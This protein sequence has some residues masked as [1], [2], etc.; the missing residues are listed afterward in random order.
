[1]TEIKASV[2]M[3]VYNDGKYLTET[4]TSICR[5][6]LKKIE[7][8]C[9]D[10]GSDDDSR[11]IIKAFA[12]KDERVRLLEQDKLSAGAA[13]NKGLAEA[14]GEYV[15]FLDSDDF[16]AEDMLETVCE[17]ADENKADVVVFGFRRYDDKKQKL[18][19]KEELPRKDLLPESEVFSAREIPEAI[20]RFTSPAPW[21]KLFRRSFLK[22]TGLEFQT[23]PNS[24]DFCFI[25]SALS[26][27]ERI[28][29][30]QRALTFYRVNVKSSIQGSKDKNPLCF[31]S[32]V[33]GLYEQL[34]S[35]GSYDFFAES[36][37]TV[38]LS[39]ALYNLRS[40]TSDEARYS[41]L[42]ALG[43]ENCILRKLLGQETELYGDKTTA[44]Y[45]E[46]LLNALSQYSVTKNTKIKSE[47]KQIIPYRG[48][49][50]I[51]VSVVIP[52]YNTGAYVAEAVGSVC[53]QSLK[54]IEIIC[55]NDGSTD[56]SPDVLKKCA[57]LDERISVWTQENAGVSCARNEGIRLAKGRYIYFMDSDDVLAENALTLLTEKADA[58]KLDV[59]YFDADVICDDICMQDEA[60]KFNYR[61][62][63]D[64]SAVYP[65]PVLFQLMSDNGDFIPTPWSQ[66]LRR[67]HIIK[68]GTF[69]HPGVIHED[70]AF[71]FEAVMNA[72]RASHLAQP[73]FFRRI[74]ENS[75]MTSEVSFKNVYGYFVSCLDMLRV[76]NEME[77]SL[78]NSVK[79]AALARISQNLINAQNIYSRIRNEAGRELGLGSDRRCFERLVVRAGNSLKKNDE[80]KERAERYE[81]DKERFSERI[82][83]LSDNYEA[84][85]I[86]NEAVTENYER[87]KS[88]YE[89]L[90]IKNEAVS[91]NY[92]RLKVHHEKLKEYK[93]TADRNCER[94]QNDCRDFAEKN[95]VLTDTCEKISAEHKMLT[96]K[97]ELLEKECEKLENNY[98]RLKSTKIRRFIVSCWENGCYYTVKVYAGG[99][100]G[101]LLGRKK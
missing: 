90:K 50:D 15:I 79:S 100:F 17:K 33:E 92:E 4:L 69:F 56:D 64:Y 94:L 86:K 31:L 21:T 78:P 58:E 52:V 55:I 22:S 95:K 26:A 93:S 11:E 60:I 99:F 23:L 5:Q 66:M 91:E 80:W 42:E 96:E 101:K 39:S 98:K 35:R 76:F 83:A 32:A 68:F 81:S 25:L 3:P 51:K 6:T 18:F 12:R 28:C 37:Q 43:D 46:T 2:I 54:E 47:I 20:F 40:V 49:D 48:K 19:E 71:T 88:Y 84:L 16:F 87:I 14:A 13:R 41:I 61:R 85:K 8:I 36:F 70:N 7:I 1:M 34:K 59:L 53:K 82:K 74:R 65:G 9:V 30:V 89:R 97:S 24:N 72:E 77:S 75:I 73:L 62:S 57:E 27:A 44:L 67:E 29:T 45:A 10:D 38:A 63:E